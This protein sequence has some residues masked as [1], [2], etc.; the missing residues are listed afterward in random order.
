[1]DAK[2]FWAKKDADG[3][4]SRSLPNHLADTFGRAQDLWN[5]WLSDAVKNQLDEK[6]FLFC[7]ALHDLGKATNHFQN[8]G[9][10]HAKESQIILEFLA[11]DQIEGGSD[12]IRGVA[13]VIGAHHGKPASVHDITDPLSIIQANQEYRFFRAE[14]SENFR[15]IWNELLDSALKAAGF[16]NLDEIPALSQTQQMLMT[17]ALIMADWIASGG[18]TREDLGFSEPWIQEFT[19]D[20]YRDRFGF[21]SP[22]VM[23]EK[24][25]QAATSVEKPG[26]LIIES[27]TG[28]GKTEAALAAAEIFA[29][30][31][32]LKGVYFA[33]PT[34]ATSDGLFG[35]FSDWV[36]Q[37][38]CEE[39]PVRLWHGKA[40]L[41]PDY[42]DV[43]NWFSDS[44]KKKLL[45]DFGVGTVDHLLVG[46]LKQKHVMLR[47]LGLANK[48]VIVD[49][50]HAY[51]AYMNVYLSR[52][53]RWLGA[54][55]VP[56]ILLSATLPAKRR[57]EL[58]Q[59]YLG[60]TKSDTTVETAYP[61]I[62]YT[63]GKEIKSISVP[64]GEQKTIAFRYIDDPLAG[65]PELR[66]RQGYIGIIVNTVK[67]SQ[68]LYRELSKQY[69]AENVTLLHSRFIATD[70]AQK[71]KELKNHLGKNAPR[72]APYFKIFIGT[73]VLEQSLD[74]DFDL[75][76]TELA[77]MDLLLQRIGRLHRHKRNSRADCFPTPECLLMA[78]DENSK[79][80]YG[81]Y[82]LMRT[83]ARLEQCA[84]KIII[85]ADVFSLVNDVYDEKIC[86]CEENEA[87]CDAVGRQEKRIAS[88]EDKAGK[89][90]MKEPVKTSRRTK[91]ICGLLDTNAGD[92]EKQGV[93]AVRDGD[94]SIEVIVITDLITEELSLDQN[95]MPDYETARKLA[96]RTIRLPR[97]LCAP[98]AIKK[99]IE[100]LETI[101]KKYSEWQMSPYLKGE[102]FLFL[103]SNNETVLNKRK[104]RYDT[105]YGLEDWK[106][107]E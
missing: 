14:E 102:L 82:L 74:I 93:A 54:Y 21:Q 48:V 29:G 17:G 50:V 39:T 106:F 36:T 65:L 68:E 3:T 53:L 40:N 8:G 84:G 5:N 16:K 62:T 66:A 60:V 47:H 25:E 45:D 107:D 1:M 59:S 33:L 35:R 23:Q 4:I 99:T 52:I 90:L 61:L 34:Q 105:N 26:I 27:E 56:V 88:Q 103:D 37:I 43:A 72:E 41:N 10:G 13:A 58:I 12:K 71:E 95:T 38:G 97:S 7:A 92:N 64:Q 63:D 11:K 9:H 55:Q 81:Q 15:K 51:D 96:K 24:V 76:I 6:A 91:D 20:I 69:G 22:N 77:P 44:R 87:Y 2:S 46:A 32:S 80:I 49:E 89:F 79:K 31:C 18:Q 57:V 70:R 100:E 19:A 85:P 67:R 101:A 86:L 83:Q 28:S 94:E 73:Q 42:I 30:K 104:L 98:W 78:P 75:L